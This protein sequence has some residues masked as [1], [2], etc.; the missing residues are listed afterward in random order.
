MDKNDYEELSLSILFENMNEK[1]IESILS[2]SSSF[3]KCFRK[4][5]FVLH[6]G[7]TTDKLGIVLQ[8]ELNI[9][10]EDYWGNSNIVE[11]VSKA[12]V[13]A[14]SYA[15]S[16][17]IPSPVNVVASKTTTVLFITAKSILSTCKSCCS[18][19]NTLI[20]NV[21]KILASKNIIMNQKISFIS[22]RTTREKITTYLSAMATKAKSSTFE[23]PFNRQ[24]LADFLSVDRSALS[25]ELSKMQKEGIIVFC[26]NRF[27]IV[28]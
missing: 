19:H 4:G 13:F 17:N 20:S 2:C 7:E 28:E 1:E 16:V 5:S 24:Q 22:R 6:A 9:Q 10:E 3:T 14:L 8:G 15:C 25:N 12:E 26:K 18:F 27:E 23:I 21:V 11:T